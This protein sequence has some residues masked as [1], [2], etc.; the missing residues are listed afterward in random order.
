MV[1]NT[2]ISLTAL[3]LIAFVLT[4]LMPNKL[5][6]LIDNPIMRI[7]LIAAPFAAMGI[8]HRLALLAVLA[9]GT[10]FFERNRR[11]IEKAGSASW[12]NSVDGE[13]IP[14]PLPKNILAEAARSEK[15]AHQAP[16]MPEGLDDDGCGEDSPVIQSDLEMRPVFE[17]VHGDSSIGNEI[18]RVV[19][20][21][22]APMPMNAWSNANDA[23]SDWSAFN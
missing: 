13:A 7:L 21:S 17:T 19:G 15:S 14:G 23:E 18:N 6:F 1:Q 4:P 5:L 3:I 10:L 12:W 11:K 20:N 2:E 8:S 16:Y 9:V 22:G